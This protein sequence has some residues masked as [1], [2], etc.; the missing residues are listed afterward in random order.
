MD[1][2]KGKD[3][4]NLLKGIK[5]V[6]NGNERHLLLHRAWDRWDDMYGNGRLDY[7]VYALCDGTDGGYFNYGP[8]RLN[9]RPYYIGSGRKGRAVNSK[10]NGRQR[11]K[12]GEKYYW[13]EQMNL[14]KKRVHIEIFGRYSTKPKANIIEIKILTLFKK[15]GVYL[16]NSQ[17]TWT[18]LP[19]SYDDFNNPPT[20]LFF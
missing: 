13:L 3:P 4:Y 20:V 19:L 10:G 7:E 14:R 8:I 2:F 15:L 12:P 1:K 18:Q 16:T 17:Y 5:E 6:Y 9:Y 11:D